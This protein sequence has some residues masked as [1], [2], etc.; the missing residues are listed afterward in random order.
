MERLVD[1]HG[2]RLSWFLLQPA[3]CACAHVHDAPTGRRVGGDSGRAALGV[4]GAVEE[5]QAGQVAPRCLAARSEHSGQRLARR[6]R[7]I[8]QHGARAAATRRNRRRQGSHSRPRARG[9]GQ[10]AGC[11]RG[12]ATC[13]P[14]ASVSGARDPVPERRGSGRRRIT[15]SMAN[16]GFYGSEVLTGRLHLACRTARS[17]AVP[18]ATGFARRVL[19]AGRGAAAGAGQPCTPGASWPLRATCSEYEPG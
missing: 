4:R 1:H 11:G 8:G 5:Q 15:G 9:R 7:E 18:G 14:R 16:V 13:A 6:C 2:P 12:K 10:G 19:F 17:L 3:E